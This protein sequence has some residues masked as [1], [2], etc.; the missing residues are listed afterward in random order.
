[1]AVKTFEAVNYR[2]QCIILEHAHLGTGLCSSFL[3]QS[4][5]VLISNTLVE[6]T[7]NLLGGKQVNNVPLFIRL[8][9]VLQL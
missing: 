2:N 7:L 5:L 3:K 6:N 9:L 4:P 8:L 1:M